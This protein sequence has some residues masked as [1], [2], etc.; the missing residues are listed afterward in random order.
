[1]RPEYAGKGSGGAS[2]TRPNLL[3]MQR[4]AMR[5]R[6]SMRISLKKRAVLVGIAVCC[7]LP[8][9]IRM[10]GCDTFRKHV[11]V[12]VPEP[13]AVAKKYAHLKVIDVHNHDTG[14]ARY[15]QSMKLWDAYGID[16]VVLFA[17]GITDPRAVL[18]DEI[19][20]KASQEYPGRILPFFSGFD[21]RSKD[22]LVYVR[23]KFDRGFW[24]IGEYV[25]ASYAKESAVYHNEWK[26]DHPMDGY[27]SEVYD[28]CAQYKAPI[29]LHVDPVVPGTLAMR[30]FEKALADHPETI[31]I[32][33][34]AN[35]FNT[36]DNLERLLKQ[37]PNLYIDFFPGFNRYNGQA[38]LSVEAYIPLIERYYSKFLV[39]S[40][41]GY[42]IDY[43]Q[44]YEAIYALLD[45]V[46][47]R[48]REHLAHKN[49]DYLLE[50]RKAA[51]TS[52]RQ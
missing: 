1:M 6:I 9:I 23:E 28:L 31:F 24:G 45:S 41:S 26:P 12:H 25:G 48:A 3:H 44:A 39:S 50:Q 5:K 10:G 4:K 36:P 7:V 38:K 11:G 40:D 47:Q 49:F 27:F 17:G 32:F 33:A 42:G 21:V 52:S 34:H 30:M 35:A 16:Q 2:P 46:S 22:A 14:G 13:S 37:Y 20:W 8:V 51:M 29:L 43:H 19:A 18:Q 15:K